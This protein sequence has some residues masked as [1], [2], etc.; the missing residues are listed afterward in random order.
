[1]R[2]PQSKIIYTQ[3][4][5][6]FEIHLTPKGFTILQ[7]LSPSESAFVGGHYKTVDE[8]VDAIGRVAIFTSSEASALEQIADT[9]KE[10]KQTL[11]DHLN[12]YGE[13]WG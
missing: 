13:C 9:L 6:E 8:L 10:I 11:T 2:N 1:M 4:G 7:V 5:E 3:Q 12:Q